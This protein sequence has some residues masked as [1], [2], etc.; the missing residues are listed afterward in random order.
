MAVEGDA[1]GAVVAAVE[2]AAGVADA[3]AA[4]VREFEP[5]GSSSA[6]SIVELNLFLRLP[7]LYHDL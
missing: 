2:G 1:E 7:V 3:V 4:V 5:N 6:L